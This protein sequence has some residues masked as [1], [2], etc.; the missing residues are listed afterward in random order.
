MLPWNEYCTGTDDAGRRLD[1]VIRRM[2]PDSSLSEIYRALRI[3]RIRVDGRIAKPETRLLKGSMIRVDRGLSSSAKPAN[4]ENPKTMP[5]AT[6]PDCLVLATEHLAFFSKPAGM[7]AHGKGSLD[8]MAR[9]WI[10]SRA[11]SSLSFA[12]GPLHRLDRNTSG[13][14]TFP[15]SSRGARVFSALLA[16]GGLLKTY[17]A[18]FSGRFEEAATWEDALARDRNLGVTGAAL[19][20]DGD[21]LGIAVTR[22]DP[23][24]ATAAASLVLV[25]IATGRTHQI[26]AQAS[27]HGF[28]LIGDRKYGG[29]A[30]EGGYLLHSFRLRFA[31]RPFHD[32]PEEIRA[33]LPGIF[34][35]RAETQFGAECL[36]DALER[37]NFILSVDSGDKAAPDKDGSSIQGG[38][39]G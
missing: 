38:Q 31:Q 33:P 1:R 25:R 28:S 8:E 23:L 4:T 14:M 22:V 20:I 6:A 37:A 12:P 16:G 21:E 26:R 19:E 13:L 18:V 10:L 2:M 30:H 27:L 36:Q 17:L 15:L 3:G 35:K 5:Y 11:E 39:S 29:A 24:L 7:L 32:L 9:P 34:C